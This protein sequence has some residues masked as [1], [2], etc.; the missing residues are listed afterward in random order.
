MTA[1]RPL[2]ASALAFGLVTAATTVTASSAWAQDANASTAPT[3]G[4]T[5]ATEAEEQAELARLYE[6]AR[7]EGGGLVV[8]AGG[9][10]PGQ[11]DY[12]RDAFRERFPEVDIDIVVDFS[13]HH[14]ARID[15]QVDNGNVVADVVHFQTIDDFPRWKEEGIL[16]QYRPLGWNQIPDTIK[17]ADGFYTGVFYFGFGNVTATTLG[18]N[19]PVEAQDFLKPEYKDKL[20]ITFPQDDDAV[21]YYFKQLTDTY[22]WDYVERLIEQNPRWVRGTQDAAQLVGT[23]GLVAAFGS[24]GVQSDASRLSFP[25]NSP[26]VAW[27]QTGA[28]LKDAPHKA[29]A[30]L[31]LSWLLSKEAQ[32]NDIGTWSA[33]NDVA[34]PEGRQGIN[35]YDNMNPLGLGE[36]MN[37]RGAL[38]RYKARINLL[39]GDVTGVNPADPEGVL[40]THPVSQDGR[41]G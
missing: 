30:Q 37:D 2:A 15:H 38:D 32:Q 1:T 3:A 13:K 12:L 28:I 41:Q 35:E 22:G 26:W 20:V 25:Q 9:D 24:A 18:D 39:V 11:A 6:Q 14:N 10:K 21:L 40:G 23:D 27:P 8:Y 36:F 16:E 34:P 19:A 31:Y 4:T 7:A 29:A 5:A 17:D 33:R